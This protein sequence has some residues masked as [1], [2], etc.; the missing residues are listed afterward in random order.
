[1]AVLHIRPERGLEHLDKW[2][3]AAYSWYVRSMNLLD[4]NVVARGVEKASSSGS[5][6]QV[7][8]MCTPPDRR[9]AAGQLSISPRYLYT[10]VF[11]RCHLDL[12]HNSTTV[13]AK[14]RQPSVL[15]NDTRR[16]YFSV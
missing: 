8:G 2:M 15:M 3:R 7:R 16:G 13:A 4:A 9:P 6:V 14:T 1:M 12:L 11:G 10:I 5:E